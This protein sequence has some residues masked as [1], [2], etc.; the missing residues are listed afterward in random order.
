MST[1]AWKTLKASSRLKRRIVRV[2]SFVGHATCS[3]YL[4]QGGGGRGR[5]LGWPVLR[6]VADGAR[7]DGVVS[8][9]H[10]VRRHARFIA[11][12]PTGTAAH[13][14]VEEWR[15]A[16][17]LPLTKEE[18]KPLLPLHRATAASLPPAALLGAPATCHL[19]FQ[20]P[21]LLSPSAGGERRRV[22]RTLSGTGGFVPI[23]KVAKQHFV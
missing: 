10:L 22:F 14:V 23:H 7:V 5:G 21:S 20:R 18:R 16:W 19:S 15:Q 9:A 13:R 17:D 4:K 12:T 3:Q 8:L 2:S 6:T 1:K 11:P